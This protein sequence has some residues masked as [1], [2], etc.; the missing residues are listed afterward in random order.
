M[1]TNPESK[2]SASPAPKRAA[3]S[4][5]AAAPPIA[6]AEKRTRVTSRVAEKSEPKSETP[7]KA[8]KSKSIKMKKSS[9]H[10]LETEQEA[11]AALKQVLSDAAGKKVKKDDLLRVAV[12]L[13]LKQTQAKVKAE[14]AAIAVSSGE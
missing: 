9:F 11:L 14:L 10:M 8:S 1:A 4:K 2:P 6:S 12:R 5:I 7:Q 13:L 3:A